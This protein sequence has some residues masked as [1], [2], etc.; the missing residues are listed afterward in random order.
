LAE[1][2]TR[3]FKRGQWNAYVTMG[4]DKE[5]RIQRLAEV[6][7]AWRDEVREHVRT[8]FKIKAAHNRRNK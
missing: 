5:D 1:V 3:Y 6:P 7:E 4:R 8:V 2:V